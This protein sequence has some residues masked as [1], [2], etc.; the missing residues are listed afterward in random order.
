M[1]IG[2]PSA[3]LYKLSFISFRP[4]E[5]NHWARSFF[6]FCS[7]MWVDV[8]G[9]VRCTEKKMCSF[10]LF[11]VMKIYSHSNR[12]HLRWIHNWILPATMYFCTNI[13]QTSCFIRCYLFIYNCNSCP[14]F[15]AKRNCTFP[16]RISSYSPCKSIDIIASNGT[17]AINSRHADTSSSWRCV[18]RK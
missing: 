4:N 8:T 17:I 15:Y 14:F 9:L 18:F 16:S 2:D 13:Y 6:L 5:F 11:R 3:H 7:P 1:K 12:H 10:Q